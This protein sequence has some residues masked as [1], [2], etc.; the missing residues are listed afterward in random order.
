METPPWMIY[1]AYGFTGQLIVDEALQRGH[2][3]L[4]AGRSREKLMPLAERFG[5]EARVI[6]LEDG[7][8]LRAALA[9]MHMVVHAAGPFR[10]TSQPMLSACLDT[11]THYLDITG[12]LPVFEHTLSLNEEARRAG[13]CLVS[14]GGID[15]VPTDCLAVTLSAQ[16]DH[17]VHLELAL[18]HAVGGASAGTV[19]S[20][21]GVMSSGGLV[22]RN[23]DL[24]RVKDSRTRQRAR[25]EHAERHLLRAQ[26]GDLVTAYASTG[27]PNIS[28]Y[29]AMSPM[30]HALSSVFMPL[31]QR[32][33]RI[34]ALRRAALSMADRFASGPSPEVQRTHYA[35]AWGCVT[36]AD[37]RSVEGRLR[38]P[39]GYRLTA[40]CSVRA[41]E[42][43]L[44]H[45]PAGALTPAQALGAD[46]IERI[47]GVVM[48]LSGDL[49]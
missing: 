19:K 20:A 32:V 44:A 2:R 45:A 42:H 6:N 25:F 47:P 13:I 40:L 30:S 10:Q 43:I 29:I 7:T 5:L 4:L 33:L 49:L 17:P 36:D 34:D 35:H 26:L 24:V 27:I 16:V 39:E 11:C 48:E 14:G 38:M 8:A 31:L 12:E 23:G 28:T 37:G 22:R 41:V 1:G 9:E 15:V 3:P 21:I 18:A 46:F